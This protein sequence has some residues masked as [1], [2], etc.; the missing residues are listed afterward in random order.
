MSNRDIDPRGDF[1]AATRESQGQPVD[2]VPRSNITTQYCDGHRVLAKL[3]RELRYDP[4]S[5][6]FF[7]IR[8]GGASRKVGGVAG[9][10]QRKLGYR[11]IQIGKSYYKAH[12]LAWLFT[13]GSIPIGYQ[14]D[15]INGDRS[16]NR[17]SN[18]RLATPS[19]NSRNAKLRRDSTTGVKG[20]S[21]HKATGKWQASLRVNGK[22]KHLGIFPSIGEARDAVVGARDEFHQDFANHGIARAALGQK[23]TGA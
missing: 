3:L 21:Y 17:I 13:Y 16:D 14:I 23:E 4:I 10:V 5:G 19:E 8:K 11:N 6:D 7:W 2:A 9:S 18:L 20:V 15:H 12:H 22:S 1:L